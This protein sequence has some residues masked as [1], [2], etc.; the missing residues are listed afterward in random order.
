VLQYY[1]ASKRKFKTR[2]EQ[3]VY[4]SKLFSANGNPMYGVHINIGRKYTPERNQKVSKAVKKW[5]AEHPEH[6]YRMGT[7]GA[8]KTRELGLN[9]IATK[10]EQIMEDALK[11]YN[12]HYIPQ[13]KYTIGFMD[14]F[15]PD[16]NIA[17]FVDGYYWHADP[18]IFQAEDMLF[19]GKTAQWVWQ[20]DLR[21]VNYLKS[22]GYTV[23]RF[24]EKEV[25]K[26]VDGCI[27]I[28][29]KCIDDYKHKGT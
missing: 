19:F 4:L 2:E 29:Q 26:N 24:W 7:L 21:Q 16:S 17:V 25:Y 14:F 11:K 23:L 12:M 1:Y 9:G 8:S 28:I 3:Y 5:A 22:Q 27:K 20:K 15:I 13:Y 10:L 6:Y 18:R